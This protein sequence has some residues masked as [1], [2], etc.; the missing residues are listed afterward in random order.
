VN[1]SLPLEPAPLLAP[2]TKAEV[3]QD[4][5]ALLHARELELAHAHLPPVIDGARRSRLLHADPIATTWEAWDTGC[6]QRVFLRCL[7]QH[8][9]NDPV[10][11]RRM[12]KAVDRPPN[13]L[14][15]HPD[16]D[17]PHLRLSVQGAMLIDRFPVEDAPVTIRMAQF[18]AGGLR[19][20]EQLHERGLIHGGPIACFLIEAPSG[21]E[22]AWLDTFDAKRSVTA[23]IADLAQTIA[24]LDPTGT[25]PVGELAREWVE[26]PPPS[27][28]DA[29]SLL[30]QTLAAHLLSARHRLAI[31]GRKRHQADRASQLGGLVRRLTRALPPPPARCCFKAT[32]EGVTVLAESD[33]IVV[34][35]GATVETGDRFLPSVYDPDQGLDAQAARFLLR[36]WATRE[37]GD[38]ATRREVQT[39]LGGTDAQAEALVRWLSGMARL[40]AAGMLLKVAHGAR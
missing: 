12:A 31:V 2:R 11:V 38:S 16:G 13:A 36:A 40:R 20:L 5:A 1:P 10:M 7:R 28:K 3:R 8:W 14:S 6:G 19:S 4:D 26:A 18:L 33:G 23:E 17:W 29:L 27:A 32:H 25:D 39:T 21:T 37:N 15:W 9:R 35:G 34:R 24:S 30:I 22:I